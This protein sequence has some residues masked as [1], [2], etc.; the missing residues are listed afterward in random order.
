[1]RSRFLLKALETA[2]ASQLRAFHVNAARRFLLISMGIT[3]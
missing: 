3:F 2:R 1:M